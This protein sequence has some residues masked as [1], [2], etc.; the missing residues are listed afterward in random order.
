MIRLFITLLFILLNLLLEAQTASVSDSLKNS[1]L[2]QEATVTNVLKEGGEVIFALYDSEENFSKRTPSAIKKVVPAAGKAS[3][4]FEEVKPGTYVVI[5]MH[6]LN[7]NE[8]M[9]FD[10]NGMPKEDYGSSNNVMRMGPPNF[11]DAKFKVENK[12]VTLEIRF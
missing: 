4:R 3:V 12:S 5:V 8:Q 10:L 11:N 7:G 1:D 9:D 2:S 6:D